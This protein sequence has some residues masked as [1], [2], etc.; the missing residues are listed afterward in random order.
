[1]NKDHHEDAPRCVSDP[2]DASIPPPSSDALFTEVYKHLRALAQ[3]HI[4]GERRDHTLQATAL[5]H[6]AFLRLA[7]D[8]RIPWKNQGHLV[9]AAAETM[10]QVLLDHAKSRGRK[11]RGGGVHRDQIPLDVL[12][13]VK[14]DDADMIESLDEA[15][16]ALECEA[17]D[18]AAVV[19]L[20]FFACQ[21]VSETAVALGM[22][23]RS[24]DRAWSYGRAW[25]FRALRAA[26]DNT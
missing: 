13:L 8:R 9:A 20:R 15:L 11:R 7:P 24:V 19:K 12:A 6:E 3:R 17:P 1:M 22:S 18:A 4:A 23:P 26:E 21:T 10:R 5:V 25:L 16:R 14:Q 2:N